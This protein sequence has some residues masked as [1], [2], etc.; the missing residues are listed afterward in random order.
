MRPSLEGIVI[1][2]HLWCKKHKD[3][4]AI[5]KPTVDCEACRALYD[6]TMYYANT[7]ITMLDDS[8]VMVSEYEEP[9]LGR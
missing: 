6:S 5:R 7:L 9:D 2:A 1:L 4:K 3:Y 8:Q